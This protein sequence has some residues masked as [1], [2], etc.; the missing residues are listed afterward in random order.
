MRVII[1]IGDDPWD[2]CTGHFTG[3]TRVE[4]DAQ[5]GVRRVH[6]GEELLILP[7]HQENTRHLGSHE[8]SGLLHD[9]LQ[10]QLGAQICVHQDGTL[11]QGIDGSEERGVATELASLLKEPSSCMA[12]RRPVLK[13]HFLEVLLDGIAQSMVWHDHL[14]IQLC[15]TDRGGVVVLQPLLDITSLV[16]VA[17]GED[18]RVVHTC[19]GD[20]AVERR[21]V[22]LSICRRIRRRVLRIIL[23]I[24]FCIAELSP[25]SK[26]RH[27]LQSRHARSAMGP[28]SVALARRGYG[29][30]ASARAR[31]KHSP[32][33]GTRT[34][35]LTGPRSVALS[36]LN[37]CRRTRAALNCCKCV[38]APLNC[39]R[40]LRRNEWKRQTRG[41]RR[42]PLH[43]AP[44]Q[45]HLELTKGAAQLPPRSRFGMHHTLLTKTEL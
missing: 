12:N 1:S 10:H 45:G 40:C 38:R 8:V 18:H 39:C 32:S 15:S 4:G 22:P 19:P 11:H 23:H 21:R 17:V 24:P 43:I 36:P 33:T 42:H 37:C 41:S 28:R 16:R 13:Q 5:L 31:R 26:F 7:V 3:Y 29:R 25:R 27:R 35:S 20:R 34:R 9:P 6:R 44:S 30:M 2:S 14:L